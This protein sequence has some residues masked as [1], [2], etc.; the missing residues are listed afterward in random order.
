MKKAVILTILAAILAM[1]V[2]KLVGGPTPT[3]PPTGYTI[4][5]EATVNSCVPNAIDENVTEAQ[6]TSYCGCV[7]D[8]G[9][10][11]Y[12]DEGFTKILVDLGDTNTIT[13]EMNGVINTCIAQVQ[14]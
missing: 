11:L 1:Y 6:A 10:A 14:W 2:G 9:V 5:R 13:P 3:T 8:E 7:Y 12:G 4:S